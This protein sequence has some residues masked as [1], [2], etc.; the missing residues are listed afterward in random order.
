MNNP[1]YIGKA[2]IESITLADTVVPSE[3]FVVHQD[4]FGSFTVTHQ[5]LA[6]GRHSHV[7]LNVMN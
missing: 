1:V 4:S 5:M 7:H 3:C 6:R 2:D